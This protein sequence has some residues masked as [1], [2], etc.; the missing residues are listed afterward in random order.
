MP[1]NLSITRAGGIVQHVSI[2]AEEWLTGVRTITG[3]MPR[4]PGIM[5]IEIDA[6]NAFPDVNRGNNRWS[7]GENR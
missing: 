5:R 2:P 1:V 6:E 4:L 3:R 7:P